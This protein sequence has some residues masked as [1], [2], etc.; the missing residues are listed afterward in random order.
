MERR[1]STQRKR[2]VDD[3]Y[4]SLENDKKTTTSF[5]EKKS[6]SLSF[7]ILY[8]FLS[9]LFNSL[10]F[11]IP[12]FPIMKGLFVLATICAMMDFLLLEVIGFHFYSCIVVFH[13]N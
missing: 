1:S 8:S 7:V 12:S 11:L 10:S 13:V 5:E 4:Y 9:F 2:E 6:R 3:A